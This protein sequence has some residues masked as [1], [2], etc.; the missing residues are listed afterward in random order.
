MAWTQV[1][2]A[3]GYAAGILAGERTRLRP[4]TEEDLEVLARWWNEPEMKV[5]QDRAVRPRPVAADVE[6][7]RTWSAN[8][9]DGGVGFAIDDLGG[10]LIGHA[11][12]H[13]VTQP[14]R[15]GTFAI[16]LGPEHQGRGLGPDATAA[17]LRY[18]FAEMGLH[19]IQLGVYAYNDRA[20]A[21]YR[22]AGFTEEGRRREAVFHDGVFHDEVL[23]AVLVHEWRAAR[24]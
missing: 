9:G 3:T 19:R 20:L 18:G 21:A 7:F 23:M 15:C 5:L 12:L 4:A 2:E 8:D 22:K 24:G 1:G 14:A 16:M 17:M 13:S 6:Q 11:V 10:T